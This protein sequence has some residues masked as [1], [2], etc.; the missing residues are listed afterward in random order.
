MTTLTDER[1]KE[2]GFVKTIDG[3]VQDKQGKIFY[4]KKVK[5]PAKVIRLFCKECLG[6]DRQQKQT[7]GLSIMIDDCTDPLCPLFDFR[8]GKNPFYTKASD[9]GSDI[10][11]DSIENQPETLSQTA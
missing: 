6:L 5:S 7:T 9:E 1:F 3:G 11:L 2:L 8:Y 4:P 10:G